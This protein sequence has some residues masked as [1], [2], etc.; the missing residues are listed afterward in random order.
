MQQLKDELG[1]LADQVD[2]EIPENNHVEISEEHGLILHRLDK[3]PDPPNKTLIVQA[4]EAATRPV[5]I[6]DILTETEQW[7]DLHRLFGPLPDSS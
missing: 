6:L 5:S 4:M 2:A 3:K 7:L 1:A